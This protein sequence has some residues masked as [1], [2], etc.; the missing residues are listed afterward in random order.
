MDAL[1]L[2]SVP[3]NKTSMT[4]FTP[5]EK[6]AAYLQNTVDSLVQLQQ[7]TIEASHD[8]PDTDAAVKAIEASVDVMVQVYSKLEQLNNGG[9]KEDQY[10]GI[11]SDVEQ[12]VHRAVS[13][14][15]AALD[16]INK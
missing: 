16:G 13:G 7:E 4:S 2:D 5:T 12:D 1:R 15:T 11:M 3:I 9:Y 6:L 14:L 8:L 10:K